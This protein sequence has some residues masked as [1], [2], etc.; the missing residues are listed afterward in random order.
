MTAPPL[1]ADVDIVEHLAGFGPGRRA[2]GLIRLR[3]SPHRTRADRFEVTL[4]NPEL[5]SQMPPERVDRIPGEERLQLLRGAIGRLVTLLVAP[6]A[7]GLGFDQRG[8]VA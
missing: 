8:P 5:T 2:A 4:A 7:V 3:D 1:V 6:E